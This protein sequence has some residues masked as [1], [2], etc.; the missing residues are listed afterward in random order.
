[1]PILL[2]LGFQ[3]HAMPFRQLLNPGATAQTNESALRLG[4]ARLW[5]RSRRTSLPL[6][7]RDDMLLR[8][9]PARSFPS[10]ERFISPPPTLEINSLGA[11]R[12]ASEAEM[13]SPAASGPPKTD[14]RTEESCH[15][16]EI[17][18]QR[19]TGANANKVFLFSIQWLRLSP[20]KQK[21]SRAHHPNRPCVD[22][23]P[24]PGVGSGALGG[25]AW[26]RTSGSALWNWICEDFE[27]F[28]ALWDTKMISEHSED[29]RTVIYLFL[30]FL[31]LNST[32]V[33]S[34]KNDGCQVMHHCVERGLTTGCR[35]CNNKLE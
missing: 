23:A 12:S 24:G 7:S 21:F 28:V 1:M 20:S 6:G 10:S 2:G 30:H 13:T 14:S 19:N 11:P 29:V 26:N 5:E 15:P 17:S 4:K 22:P 35:P 25:P 34:A 3:I 8:G 9:E 18:S 27:P 32:F 31:H 33:L 16:I